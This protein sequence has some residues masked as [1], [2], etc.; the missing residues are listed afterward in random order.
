[1]T[2]DTCRGFGAMKASE[3]NLIDKEMFRLEFLFEY[4]YEKAESEMSTAQILLATF[5]DSLER[6]RNPRKKH[7]RVNT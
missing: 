7:R 1:M 4:N 6:E 5:G 2:H 3:N